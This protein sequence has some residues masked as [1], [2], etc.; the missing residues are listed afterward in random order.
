MIVGRRRF[1]GDASGKPPR[2]EF[3][4]HFPVAVDMLGKCLRPRRMRPG[5]GPRP[6][7]PP[8]GEAMREADHAR[9]CGTGAVLTYQALRG[10]TPSNRAFP[11]TRV[12]VR[13]GKTNP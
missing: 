5:S 3:P 4:P 1:R 10:V 13:F 6:P 8:E 9:L 2:R 12:T 11:R 7:R